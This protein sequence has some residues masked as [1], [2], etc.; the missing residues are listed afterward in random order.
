MLLEDL[1]IV[2][3]LEQQ[4]YPFPWSREILNDCLQSGLP[5]WVLMNGSELYGYCLISI[6][7][8]ESHLLNLCINPQYQGQQLG[9]AL[10]DWII[11][12]VQQRR[13]E[14]L[15]L[16]VRPSNP[17]AISLYESRGFNQI[18]L[19]PEY[20]RAGGVREDAIVMALQLTNG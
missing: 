17:V 18:G 3:A 8:G 4:T 10:L 11:I 12:E 1:D 16:E 13:A 9:A 14:V 6:G 2:F 5:A 20:Y 19:R 7:A 15:F